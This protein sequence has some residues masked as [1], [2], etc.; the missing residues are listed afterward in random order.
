MGRALLAFAV[1]AVC[2]LLIAACNGSSKEM[3]FAVCPEV[4]TDLGTQ[5]VPADKLKDFVA[6]TIG[7]VRVARTN[8]TMSRQEPTSRNEVARWSRA[9]TELGSGL[10]GCRPG[11][12]L[13]LRAQ[14]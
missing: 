11:R 8:P 7:S 3:H 1:V 4:D 9:I 10:C 14:C 2:V 12:R 5:Y 13:H 6:G